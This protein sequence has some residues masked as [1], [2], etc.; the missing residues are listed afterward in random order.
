[1]PANVSYGYF[2]PGQDVTVHAREDL[3]G[4]TFVRAAS[5]GRGTLP[6]GRTANTGESKLGVAGHD[7]AAGGH[8]HVHVGGSVDVTAGADISAGDDI[9]VGS[10]GQAVPAGEDDVVVGYAT[11]NAAS[12]DDAAVLLK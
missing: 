12:G 7:V 4:K 11:N 1:M 6:D 5:G 8:V 9:A 10:D 3:T 2:K